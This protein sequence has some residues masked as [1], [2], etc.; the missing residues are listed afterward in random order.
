MV[1]FLLRNSATLVSR[2]PSVQPH[3]NLDGGGRALSPALYTQRVQELGDF[4]FAA[5][6]HKLAVAKQQHFKVVIEQFTQR[7]L[8]L[9]DIDEIL[10][11]NETQRARRVPVN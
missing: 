11:R 7:S 9:R 10:L 8:E 6:Q 1:D 3:K 5:A 2:Y 4:Q